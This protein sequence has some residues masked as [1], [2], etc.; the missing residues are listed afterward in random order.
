MDP[1]QQSEAL[2]ATIRATKKKEILTKKRE[3]HSVMGRQAG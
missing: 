1:Q 2:A 3:A